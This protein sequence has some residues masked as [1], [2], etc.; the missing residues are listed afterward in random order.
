MRKLFFQMM[1]SLDGYF[2]PPDKRVDWHV[3]DDDFMRY[4]ADMLDSIDGMVMGRVV[5]EA[6]AAVWPTASGPH[7]GPM[8]TLPKFVVSRTLDRLPVAWNNARLLEGDAVEQIGK[9]K[10]QPGKPLSVGGSN[11]VASLVP[12]GLVDEYR[13]L[14]API[15][16]GGGT[17]LFHG[18]RDRLRLKLVETR[19]FRS[20]VV[21][22]HYH[23]A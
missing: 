9:L 22:Q 1:V 13:I 20:G 2:E 7:A 21:A 8:N 3:V 5:Y 23:P 4:V 10:Q 18:I 17:P 16:L 6:M 12:S 19:T 14:V 15:V 11:L